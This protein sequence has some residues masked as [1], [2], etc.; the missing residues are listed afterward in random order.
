MGFVTAN[1]LAF[2]SKCRTTSCPQSLEFFQHPPAPAL[3][4]LASQS[5]RIR[6]LCDVTKPSVLLNLLC[7]K[8]YATLIP[9]LLIPDVRSDFV[10]C[11]E[12]AIVAYCFS[13]SPATECLFSCTSA[14]KAAVQRFS[15]FFGEGFNSQVSSLDRIC[16]Q[17]I[18]PV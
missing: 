12:Q 17:R 6:Y 8:H 18:E 9:R 15:F 2:N 10:F 3:R 7:S 16:I 4:R 11:N 13:P 14:D 1:S 5:F